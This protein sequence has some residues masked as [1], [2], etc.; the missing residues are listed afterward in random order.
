MADKKKKKSIGKRLKSLFTSKVL[1]AVGNKK[2]KGSLASQFAKGVKQ[3][4]R[5]KK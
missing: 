5:G 3:R 1:K 4:R 2:R